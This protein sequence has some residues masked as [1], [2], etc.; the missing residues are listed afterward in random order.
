MVDFIRIIEGYFASTM[1][2]D[3]FLQSQWSNR[4]EYGQINHMHP[5]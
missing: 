4:E 3:G 1:T 5:P 2:I